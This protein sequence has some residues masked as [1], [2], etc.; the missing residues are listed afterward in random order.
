MNVAIYTRVSTEMQAEEGHSLEAQH[1][2]LLEYIRAQ[3]WELFRIYTDPGVSAKDL[4][5]PGVQ[6]LIRDLKQGLFDAVLVHK[7]DRLTRN[8]SDL[9]DLVEMVNKHNIKM[10]SFSENIDT[11]TPMGRMFVYILGIF[12]QMHRE[13]LREEVLK[14]MTKRAEKGLHNV[15]VPMY[16]YTRDEEGNLHIVES[17]AK[18]VRFIFERY[19][20]GIGT[21]SIAKELN[22]L[23]IR[24]NQGAKWD[25]HKVMLTLTNLHYTGKIHWKAAHLAEEHRIIREGDHEPIISIET[26]EQAQ[27]ILQRRREGTISRNSYDYVFGGIV[28][29]GKCGGGYKAKY[30]KRKLLDGTEA[31]YRGYVCSGNE[32][33]GTCDAPGIS[34]QNLVKLLFSSG[35]LFASDFSDYDS[36]VQGEENNEREELEQLIQQS[37]LK[38]ARWQHAYGEGLMSYEDFAKRMKEEMDK[39]KVWQERLQDAS[40]VLSSTISEEEAAEVLRNIKADWDLYDQSMKKQ[41]IQGLFQ[42]IVIEKDGKWKI[43]ECILA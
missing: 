20:Q 27:R 5:R 11:S 10:I 25:Q 18:W 4:K 13:N 29:C 28:K 30:N 34:E 35:D 8:I 19:I 33:Y 40:P 17:E 3:G 23:G 14:G 26:Y 31:T 38:R 39:L 6:E 43:I 36:N 21:T 12:A 9:Y 15:T 32:R 2:R 22:E 1:D 7:L 16:G 24:R 42:R 37:E 41:I